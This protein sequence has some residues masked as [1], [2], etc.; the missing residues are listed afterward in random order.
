MAIRRGRIRSVEAP[1]TKAQRILRVILED[2]RKVFVPRETFELLA[3]AIDLAED[4]V[5]VERGLLGRVAWFG[6]EHQLTL[7]V[8]T[9][10]I[11]ELEARS[12][13]WKRPVV[14]GHE[15][16]HYRPGYVAV[17]QPP[18]KEFIELLG[19]V[20]SIDLSDQDDSE[21]SDVAANMRRAAEMWAAEPF[22]VFE[23]EEGTWGG[24]QRLLISSYR[25]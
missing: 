23:C 22:Q 8:E 5:F 15:L 20:I 18:P 9:G 1:P 10:V 19:Q 16:R 25:G 4:Q 13:G 2:G 7:A 24:L 12:A 3:E 11:S 14:M 21:A 17:F 6:P